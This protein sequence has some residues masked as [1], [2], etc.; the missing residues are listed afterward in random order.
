MIDQQSIVKNYW[1]TFSK[2]FPHVNYPTFCQ[3][4]NSDPYGGWEEAGHTHAAG[5]R[6]LKMLYATILSVVPE[7]I[8]EIGTY[9]GNSL[10][11]IMAAAKSIDSK[12]TSIDI[13]DYGGFEGHS[14][15]K[16]ISSLDY[17]KDHTDHDFVFQ[18]GNHSE[19]YVKLEIE[20]L[21]QIETVKTIFAHD[22]KL[23][24]YIERIYRNTGVFDIY[25]FSEPAYK[26]G[27]LIAK[28][29]S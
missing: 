15:F 24:P 16:K 19:K 28:R 18:D 10:T 21:A 9:K 22:C 8:L 1:L 26:A 4:I 25:T 7:N 3:W 23:Y 20:R 13:T 29:K 27:F 5:R 14:F 12:V 6:E 2:C 11:H 17:L